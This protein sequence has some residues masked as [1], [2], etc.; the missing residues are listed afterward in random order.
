MTKLRRFI[1]WIIGLF[2][3]EQPG[4][5]M[6]FYQFQYVEGFPYHFKEL[7]IYID[8]DELG[9]NSAMCN[10]PCGCGDLIE[11]NLIPPIRPLWHI[12]EIKKRATVAPSVNKTGGC[13]SHFYI[14]DGVV[15]WI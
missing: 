2:R 10:C 13:N 6:D 1:Q 12:S 9:Y 11:L 7:T 4:I 15:I 8:H 14:R 3:K 5:S